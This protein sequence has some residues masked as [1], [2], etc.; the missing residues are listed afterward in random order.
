MTHEMK[1]PRISPK[2]LMILL[3]REGFKPSIYRSRVLI[4]AYQL[5]MSNN[6][7]TAIGAR[8]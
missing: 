4:L 1:R 8:G 5:L 6:F 2:P 3:G 7:K